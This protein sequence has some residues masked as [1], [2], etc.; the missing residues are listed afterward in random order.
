MAKTTKNQREDRNQARLIESVRRWQQLL[1][2]AQD[3]NFNGTVKI[4]IRANEGV[5]GRIG[6]VIEGFEDN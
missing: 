2:V 6:T 4:Y 5:L 1:K 3:P